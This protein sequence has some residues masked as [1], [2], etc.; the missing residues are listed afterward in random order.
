MNNSEILKNLLTFIPFASFFLLFV[1]VF[2]RIYL[3]NFEIN[4]SKNKVYGFL[5]NLKTSKMIAI[6]S[7]F[8]NYL[9]LIWWT[10]SFT[11]INLIYI[12]F[13]LVLLLISN[14]VLDNS[15]GVFKS[16]ILLGAEI[17]L[18][19]VIFLI[20][21][22]AKNNNLFFIIMI[23]LIIFA[24]MFYSYLFIKSINNIV[25]RD[26]NIKRKNEYKV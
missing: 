10:I 7:L 2:L 8:I 3:K 12:M 9:F 6:S 24:I 18:I 11:G 21:D 5:L 22:L 13:S 15:S 23:L 17:L 26:R 19:W 1:W 20:F 14:V 25:I 4:S 16:V